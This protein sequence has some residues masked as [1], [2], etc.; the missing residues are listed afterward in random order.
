M[1]L[2]YWT[3]EPEHGHAAPGGSPSG[4]GPRCAEDWTGLL[5]WCVSRWWCV[6]LCLLFSARHAP[7][8]TVLCSHYFS[9]ACSGVLCKFNLCPI[10]N[11]FLWILSNE[12][13]VWWIWKR[14]LKDSKTSICVCVGIRVTIPPEIPPD[15]THSFKL[16]TNYTHLCMHTQ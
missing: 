3:F 12:K 16:S 1:C 14:R 15:L 11:D 8:H 13:F 10:R 2:Q 4:N 7:K 5:V 6:L 9:S